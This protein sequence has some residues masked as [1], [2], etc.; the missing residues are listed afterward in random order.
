MRLWE[1]E[2]NP[3]TAET[4]KPTFRRKESFAGNPVQAKKFKLYHKLN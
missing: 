2:G 4:K 3:T 1:R